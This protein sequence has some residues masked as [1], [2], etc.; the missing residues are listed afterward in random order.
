MKAY[1]Q[2]LL[3]LT[4]SPL[5]QAS[6]VSVFKF[7]DGS[8]N[9]QY[10]ANTSGGLLILSLSYSLIRLIFSQ[11]RT[12]RYNRELEDTR[13]Q[14]ER[15]VLERTATLDESN[16]LLQESNRELEE[17]I[18]EHRSTMER[19]RMSEAYV[20]SILQSMPTMLIGLGDDGT[21]TQW[22]R[23]AQ[24]I[25][26]F[27]AET[28]LGKNLWQAY[29]AI[30]VSPDQIQAALAGNKTVTIT[31]SQRGQFYFDVTIYPLK[32]QDE[33]GVVVMI[34]DVTQ[35]VLVEN[36]LIQRDKLSSMGELAASMAH[37]IDAPLQ[38]ILGDI[39]QL[40]TMADN[41]PGEGGETARSLLADARSRGRQGTAV[42]TNLLAFSSAR[43]GE[44]RISAV[45]DLIDYSLGLANSMLSL[46]S[47]LRFADI[48]VE[49]DYAP[50]LPE[51]PCYAA[52]LHQ[53]F[54]SLFRHCCYAL[55]GAREMG[56]EPTITIKVQYY[57]EALWI[58]VQHNGRIMSPKEQ[59]YIFEPFFDDDQPA[60][61]DD[62]DASRRLSFPYYIISEQH[63]G[64]LAVTSDT[65]A[66]TTFH[67]QLPQA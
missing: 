5:S 36:K 41:L 35:Q 51:V 44:K 3:L 37:D 24:E 17:E 67:I 64:Q 61:D 49:R 40:Q 14:L 13:N 22:N 50:D 9:W 29:P 53:V 19:L 23:R 65:D 59:Q 21:I 57:Y 31:Q 42:T 16:R 18:G 1:L 47:G 62:Y 38:G 26:G 56:R 12:K 33:T 8:T 34:D 63:R 58:K 46:S 45:T 2:L 43:V 66:G 52:E 54:L 27:P 4:Y 32:D 7:E 10:L 48:R 20:A 55:D 30:T 11:R 25:S 6:L 15:R 28:V 60:F 39:E